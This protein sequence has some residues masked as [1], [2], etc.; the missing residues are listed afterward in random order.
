[1]PWSPRA[2]S[3]LGLVVAIVAATIGCD[4]V[5]KTMATAL[6]GEAPRSFL[7]D[8]VRLEY[9]ENSGAFL[10]LGRTLSERARFWVLTAG[11]TA[12][13]CAV[14]LYVLASIAW[15]GHDF[16]PWS[17]LL[18]GGISNLI[19]RAADGGRVVDFLNLGIGGLR[20]GVFNCADLAITLGAAVLLWRHLRGRPG[21]SSPRH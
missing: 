19:D 16:L 12:L 5:T 21:P 7:K 9:A 15:G 20:T 2:V 13:L 3:R 6:R 4:R 11:T 8:T 10:G 17:L 14:A 18:A 1:M